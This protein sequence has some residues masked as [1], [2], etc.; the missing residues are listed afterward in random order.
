[1]LASLRI[2]A[3][4][5]PRLDRFVKMGLIG[6]LR[7]SLVL[8]L[9]KTRSKLNFRVWCLYAD[10]RVTRSGIHYL[11]FSLSGLLWYKNQ[12]S[13]SALTFSIHP[14]RRIKMIAC[15]IE[16]ASSEARLVLLD[17][18]KSIFQHIDVEPRKLKIADDENADEVRAFRDSLY[19]FFRE[20]KVELI[21]IKKRGKKGDYA[22]GP[23][24]FKL[25]A[26]VQLYEKCPIVLIAPATISARIKKQT[27][28]T[29][30]TLKKYQYSAFQT[31]FSALP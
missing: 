7:I 22:G 29:P 16:M 9:A 2:L 23:I 24:G 4:H 10:I 26:I 14:I 8:S 3:I 28:G 25:E 5:M 6:R 1:M 18:N 15:G 31:A 11:L 21:A 27:T 20:N 13:S 30:A 19:I 17:G 12:T